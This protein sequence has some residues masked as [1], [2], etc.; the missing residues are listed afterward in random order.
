MIDAVH[1]QN[2]SVRFGAEKGDQHAP[3]LTIF[4]PPGFL[5][6]MWQFSLHKSKFFKKQ[7]QKIGCSEVISALPPL[8][9]PLL[10]PGQQQH[11]GQGWRRLHR[12]SVKA[13]QQQQWLFFCVSGV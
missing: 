6:F 8:R 3:L 11:G 13:R 5:K 10:V 9:I 1:N 7:K 2:Q 12:D 4:L